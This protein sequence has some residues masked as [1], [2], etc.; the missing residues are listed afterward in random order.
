MP[1]ILPT[2]A[3]LYVC[4]PFDKKPG[5]SFHATPPVDMVLCPEGAKPRDDVEVFPIGMTEL[6]WRVRYKKY[7]NGSC[8][9]L[10]ET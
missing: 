9:N 8:I 6:D 3:M 10:Q 7:R 2:G 1:I 5:D 4:V